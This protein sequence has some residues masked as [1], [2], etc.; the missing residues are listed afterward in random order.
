[1]L[2]IDG[3]QPEMQAKVGQK[4]ADIPLVLFPLFITH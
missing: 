4:S 2:G 1:M 3:E